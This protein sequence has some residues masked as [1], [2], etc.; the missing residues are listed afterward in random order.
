MPLPFI[1]IA[2]PVLHSSGAWIASTAASSYIAGTLS[3]TWIGAFVLGNSTLLGS[4]GLVSAAGVFGATGGLAALSSSAALGVG[5][6]LTTIGLGGVASALGIAPTVTFLG[7][8]PIGWV[9]AGTA[10][11]VVATLGY[12]LT[13]KTMRRINEEREKG[14]LEP[15]TL[16]EIVREVRL[17]EAQ[18]LETILARLDAELGN[19]S[20]SDDHKE[21]TV[22]GQLF[23]LN[24]LKYVVN[25]DG[26]EEL[27]FVTRTGR[28]QRVLLVKCAP[29]PKG[30]PA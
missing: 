20:L 4:F 29:E 1:V 24:R 21:L 22:D 7:L 8:T 19:V 14:G 16:K 30:F 6:A 2:V 25:R 27:V 11:T 23:S 26:S 15:T 18:S 28:K 5:S 17:L 13:R 3:S 9:I 10:A 12:Y